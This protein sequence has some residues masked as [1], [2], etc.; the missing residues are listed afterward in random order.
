M[1]PR[2]GKSELTSRRLPAYFLGR[3]PDIKIVGCSYSTPLARD[4]N[5][6]VQRIIVSELYQEVFP[7]TTLNAKNVATDSKGAYKRN[8]DEFEIVGY[9][10][11]YIGVGIGGALTGRDMDIGIIDDPVKDAQDADSPVQQAA[12]WEWYTK[13]FLSREEAHTRQLITQTRWAEGDLSGRILKHLHSEFKDW[14]IISLPAIKEK[15][16]HPED[17]REIGEALWPEKKTLPQLYQIKKVDP[18]GFQALYQQDPKPYKGGLVYSEWETCTEKEF[19]SVEVEEF[20]GCD[21]GWTNPSCLLKMKLL[22]KKLYIKEVIYASELTNEQLGDEMEKKD[23]GSYKYIG[24]DSNKPDAIKE[25]KTRKS[26]KRRFNVKA[27]TKG[28]GSVYNGIKKMNEYRLIIV[29]T[30]ENVLLEIANYRWKEDADGKPLPEPVKKL[31]HAMD[32]G[33]YGLR[34][35]LRHQGG[36]M[37]SFGR[38]N[39]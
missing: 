15:P 28:Q 19:D 11:K 4:F 36:A 34:N 2:H 16:T 38:V 29:E 3:N 35:Y 5:R 21:F 32:A 20:F 26:P 12:K 24:A 13:V 10:G 18:R 6:D 30:S 39:N 27:V 1:P 31:D 14:T 17:K 22:G 33:R 8:A 23:V 25:L 9:K 37:V 7:K